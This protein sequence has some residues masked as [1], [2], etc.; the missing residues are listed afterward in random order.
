MLYQAIDLGVD[1]I[2][3]DVGFRKMLSEEFK[4][5][6]LCLCPEFHIKR[7]LKKQK[8]VAKLHGFLPSQE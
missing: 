3:E 2:V 4:R 7:P 5:T 6:V 8:M 1:E